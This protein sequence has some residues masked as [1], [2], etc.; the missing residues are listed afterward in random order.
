MSNNIHKCFENKGI[1]GTA[2]MNRELTDELI[3]TAKITPN[4][5]VKVC[6][7]G[8][9]K[10]K[11][12]A[13]EKGVKI[14][15]S[16]RITIPHGF[17]S[18]QTAAFFEPG[19]VTIESCL[20]KTNF[21]I[22]IQYDIFCRLDSQ[23]GHTGAWGRN[24]FVFIED[25]AMQL[26][27]EFTLTYGNAEYYGGEDFSK[28]GVYVRE[29]SGIAEFIIAVDPDGSRRAPFSGYIRIADIPSIE[30]L[31]GKMEKIK[32]IIP[33]NG[34]QGKEIEMN[35]IEIDRF[36]NPITSKKIPTVCNNTDS[37]RLSLDW[38]GKQI[39]TN[40]IIITE[41]KTEMQLYWGDIHGHTIHSDGLGT[42]D[43]YFTFARDVASLDFSAITDH[44][45]IGPRLADEEWQLLQQKIKQY[46]E[47]GKFI[48]LLG[49]EYRNGKCD[50][51]VYYPGQKGDLLRGNDGDLGDVK[52][53]TQQVG[54]LN[55]M[56]IPHMHFGADWSG[57]DSEVYR[58]IEVYSQHGS[59]E[60]KDCPR[61]IP[62]LQKQI[63]KGSH[64]NQNSYVQKALKLGFKFGIT[65]GSDTHSG[66]PGLSDWTRVC[67][68]YPGGLTAVYAPELTRDEIWKALY[69][70]R[71]YATTGNRSIL[72]FSINSANMG[73]EIKLESEITRELKISCI[74]DGTLQKLNIFRSGSLWIEQNLDGT[75]FEKQYNDSEGSPSDWYYV[76]IDLNDGEM[77]W[78]SPIWI[79]EKKWK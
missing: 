42:I 29:L 40:P 75:E 44:D 37:P 71:C 68:T 15:G 61:E 58:V 19:F 16:V 8:T 60:Y 47:D 7:R 78:S 62:Y 72:K 65:A 54:Q 66:R 38:K 57:F 73:S 36:N 49:H 31:P 77:V 10:I 79:N 70:R 41:S 23:T 48:L 74:A 55:G 20:E 33:S 69:E 5:P 14:G 27:E 22:N 12:I 18:P 63:Q 2:K 30:V 3:G 34:I 52:V 53:L 43:E 26:G 46:H 1:L 67:R 50:M 45:D 9:W 64:S 24:I 51:N 21:R 4:Q 17:T 59:A 32:A 35:L 28:A 39:K 25:N 56:I 13:G 6:G 11:F 76:R